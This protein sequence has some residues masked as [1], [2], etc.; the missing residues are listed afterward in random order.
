MQL[1]TTTFV[2][3]ILFFSNV[4]GGGSGFGH[5]SWKDLLC[6]CL[7]LIEQKIKHQYEINNLAMTCTERRFL[8]E[9]EVRAT[10]NISFE[11]RATHTEQSMVWLCRNYRNGNYKFVWLIS[12]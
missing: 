11:L 5:P 4:Y 10:V 12:H 7:Q 1:I 6:L 9:F 3:F 2:A 8:P